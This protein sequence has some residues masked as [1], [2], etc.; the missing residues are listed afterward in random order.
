MN[1]GLSDRP[2]APPKTSKTLPLRDF[3][4]LTAF[5]SGW[6]G[7][8]EQL[9]T[10]RFEGEL[11]VVRGPTVRAMSVEY[12]QA[13]LARG[14]ASPGQCTVYTVTPRNALGIW[15]GRRL[16]PGRLVVHGPGGSTDHRSAR[17]GRSSGLSLPADTLLRAA[18]I[19]RPA[20]R[21]F[22]LPS[23]EALSP[24]PEVAAK[25]NR[26][27]ERLLELRTAGPAALASPDFQRFEQD[28]I[29]AAVAG[30]FPAETRWR[31]GLTLSGRTQLLR[32][33]DEFLR[34]R[35][36]DPIGSID[37][38]AEFGI[39]DRTLRLAFHERFG[40]GP[41]TYFRMLRLNAARREFKRSPATSVVVVARGHGFQH[42]GN[43][44]ADYRR[45]FGE[46]PSET[47]RRPTGEGRAHAFDSNGESARR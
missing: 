25:L 43:F 3:D 28:C 24:P 23:W 31:G 17:T 32:R 41:M 11:Q 21:D 29:R 42:L 14:A 27:I 13:I 39:S 10:G 37:L 4:D 40:V 46:L 22:R 26:H 18:R 6:D 8:F 34:A 12:N 38:C 7:R 2:A 47:L 9:S 30:I 19:L 5:Y 33:A 35:L 15:Q 16:A 36:A 45:A 44:A 1:T 20:E